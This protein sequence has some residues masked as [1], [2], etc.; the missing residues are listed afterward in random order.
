MSHTASAAPTTL[1]AHSATSTTAAADG[2]T[3]TILPVALSGELGRGLYFGVV[4]GYAVFLQPD[5]ISNASW[6]DCAAF[7]TAAGGS[8]PTHHEVVALGAM[9]ASLGLAGPYWM[10]D[11]ANG[12]RALAL[13]FLTGFGGYSHTS[14][15]F[16]GLVVRR[17]PVVPAADG[18]EVVA[19]VNA[20]ADRM[21]DADLWPEDDELLAGIRAMLMLNW[22]LDSAQADARMSRFN[23]KVAL[24]SL[25]AMEGGA[26]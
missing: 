8:L 18:V 24:A 7:A 21:L 1:G 5:R 25:G 16:N 19:D 20:V 13:S 10:A 15:E 23:F 6:E 11:R 22:G 4:D 3:P 9:S 26:A 17:E 12:D 14:N 2:V